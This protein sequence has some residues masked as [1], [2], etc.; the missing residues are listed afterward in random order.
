MAGGRGSERRRHQHPPSSTH[1][2]VRIRYDFE[3]Q[4]CPFKLLPKS[5]DA[6]A[7]ALLKKCLHDVFVPHNIKL[8]FA[9]AGGGGRPLLLN[10]IAGPF[11]SQCALSSKL[12]ATAMEWDA[13]G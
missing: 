3:L 6:W 10:P 9:G 11:R 13:C 1:P 8:K 4:T 2:Y 7:D 12:H 5:Q